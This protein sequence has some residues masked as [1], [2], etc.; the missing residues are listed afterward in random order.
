MSKATLSIQS[1]AFLVGD[2]KRKTRE[3][4]LPFHKAYKGADAFQR[5]DLRDRWMLGHVMGSLDIG[6]I[7]ADRILSKPRTKRTKEQQAAYKQA[8]ADFSYHVIRPETTKPVAK[9]VAKPATSQRISAK[10]RQAAEAYLA[11]FEDAK[12]AL[13]VLRAVAK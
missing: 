9:P 3:G 8:S 12:S 1:Y 10:H 6:E 2:T 7:E 11:L 4:S 13:A 5:K